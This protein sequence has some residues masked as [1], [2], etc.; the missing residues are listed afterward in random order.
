MGSPSSFDDVII[1]TDEVRELRETLQQVYLTREQMAQT[2]PTRAETT[3]KRVLASLILVVVVVIG[4]QVHDLHV[5]AC[6][7]G[8]AAKHAI[9]TA[10]DDPEIALAELVEAMYDPVPAHCDILFP[11]HRHND[12]AAQSDHRPS[13][14]ALYLGIVF[15]VTYIYRRRVAPAPGGRR[16]R[17]RARQRVAEL[18]AEARDLEE[19]VA[20]RSATT[21]P[22]PEGGS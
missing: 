1:L 17:G 19:A 4:V 10:A 18:E 2:F 14:V 11:T 16:A 22:D 12:V 20:A 6:G 15:V 9:E 5:E 21:P 7:P 8:A 3:R 13:G